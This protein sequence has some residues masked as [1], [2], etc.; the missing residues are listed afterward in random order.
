MLEKSLLDSWSFFK[1]H[2]IAIAMIVLPIVAPVGIFNSLYLYFTT[3]EEFV[4]SEHALPMVIGLIAHPVYSIAIIF[5]I[6]SVVA[7]ERSDTKSLWNLGIKYWLAYFILSLIIGIAVGFGLMLFI[8]PGIVLLARCAFAEFDLLLNQSK[9]FEAISNSWALTK[10]YM[11][12][13]LAGYAVITLALYVPYYLISG[14]FDEA[15]ILY[16]I[17]DTVLNIGYSVLTVMYTIFAFRVYEL[18][19]A[20]K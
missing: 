6:A 13:I 19:R 2:I 9:P 20:K 3:S 10:E 7:G 1:N 17:V 14:L 18:A 12:V 16:W 11:W 15:T 8:I 4:L 5:Y